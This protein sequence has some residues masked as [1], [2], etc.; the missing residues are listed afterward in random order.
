MSCLDRRDYN[1][2]QLTVSRRSK[3]LILQGSYT[4]SRVTGNYPGLISYDNGQVDPNI[5]SQ[6]DL[7]ELLANR[8]GA[9]PQDRPHYIKLDGYYVFDFKKAGRATLGWRARALSGVPR[10]VLAG[11]PLY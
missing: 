2:L 9:L 4:Y 3:Q 5:S 8:Q 6:Y 1:A 10:N 7:I 11:H